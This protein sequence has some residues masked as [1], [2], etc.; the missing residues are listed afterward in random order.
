MSTTEWQVNLPKVLN[1]NPRSVYG[2]KKELETF[3]K[4]ES[5]DLI[6]ISESWEREE[7]TLEKLINIEDYEVISKVHQRVGKGGRPA[8][9][10]NKKRFKVENLTNTQVSIP[11]G[12][13]VVWVA[14]TP[15][16]VNN[17]SK[18]QKVIV[19]SIYSKPG[20]RKKTLLLDHIAQVYG[21]FNAKY[22]NG[23]H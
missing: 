7:I 10:V 18:I 9:I 12:V 16:N 11:W 1:V 13:E 15:L 21:Q 2:K 5:V 20:S 22:K 4:E 19:A 6:C 14:L 23:L 8:V 3:I 17:A